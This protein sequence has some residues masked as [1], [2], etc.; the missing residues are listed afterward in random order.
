Q[1]HCPNNDELC[2]TSVFLDQHLL[3]GAKTDLD[4]ILEAVA[5]VQKLAGTL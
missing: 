5:K 3:I 4:D 2:A 1:N